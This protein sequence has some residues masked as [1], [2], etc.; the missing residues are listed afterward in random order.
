MNELGNAVSSSS[1]NVLP[2]GKG[3]GMVFS[4]VLLILGAVALLTLAL[5]IWARYFRKPTSQHRHRSSK[6]T[7]PLVPVATDE[8]A[9]TPEGLRR[10]KLRRR[11]RDHRPR[12][13]TLAETGGLPPAHEP[14]APD[15]P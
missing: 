12:N 6:H 4:D 10:V 15:S 9:D 8:P 14:E 1:A 13:P 5:F 11:R 7:S 3:G 2:L